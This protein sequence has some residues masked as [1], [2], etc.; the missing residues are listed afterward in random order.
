MGIIQEGIEL[1]DINLV[2]ISLEEPDSL[3]ASNSL[4]ELDNLEVPNSQEVDSDQQEALNSLGASDIQQEGL[5][6]EDKIQQQVKLNKQAWVGLD[7]QTVDI[8]ASFLGLRKR[9][10]NRMLPFHLGLPS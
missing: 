10:T 1:G 2:G 7:L 6:K 4:E 8:A 5:P 3:E 9:V